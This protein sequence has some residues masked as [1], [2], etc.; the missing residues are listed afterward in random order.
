[1]PRCTRVPGPRVADTVPVADVVVCHNVLYNVADIPPFVAA[2]DARARRRVVIEITPKHPQDRRR[3]LWRHFWNL[4]RPHEPTAATAVEAIAEAGLNPIAEESLLPEDPRAA[5]RPRVRGRPMVPQPVPAAR[6]R[7]RG[8]R[9]RRRRSLPPR[10][11]H[12][13]VGR[14]PL[15]AIRDWCRS[16]ASHRWR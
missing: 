6:A 4:E 9:A 13:L 2:L 12:H 11:G 5:V 14:R 8:G 16:P 7:A 10:A 1:M 15:G 3:M